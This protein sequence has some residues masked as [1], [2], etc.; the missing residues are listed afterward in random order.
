MNPR[1]IVITGSEQGVIYPITMDSFAIGRDPRN[2][3]SLTDPAASREHCVILRQG[4][5]FVIRDLGSFHGTLVN[6]ARVTERELLHGDSIRIGRTLLR[7]LTDEEIVCEDTCCDARTT[8]IP[9]GQ[10]QLPGAIE[11]S[12]DLQ[13]LLR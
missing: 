8:A 6:D 4:D 11:N 2:R 7:F 5:N 1:L 12:S 9:V 10:A 3:L 13:T